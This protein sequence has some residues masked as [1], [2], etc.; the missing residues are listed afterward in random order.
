MLINELSKKTGLSAHTIRFYER[1]G[2]IK[3]KR[4]PDISTN[5]YFHYDEDCI[6][7]L[8]LIRDA[9]SVGFTISEIS[10]LIEAWYSEDFTIPQKIGLLDEKLTS[11]ALKIDELEQMRELISEFKQSILE[12]EC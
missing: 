9:K 2:L 6:E 11:I 3:G 1:S 5:N 8:Q 12:R 7:R 10:N 4:N